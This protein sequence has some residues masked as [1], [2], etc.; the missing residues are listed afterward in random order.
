M[1]VMF[2]IILRIWRGFLVSLGSRRGIETAIMT[3]E[4]DAFI[5]RF[6]RL[7]Q[8]EATCWLGCSSFWR[9]ALKATSWY[10]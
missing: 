4:V 7:R 2:A 3:E 6:E 10:L 9:Y 1:R 5:D 8:E